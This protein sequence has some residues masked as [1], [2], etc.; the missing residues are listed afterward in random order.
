MSQTD[1]NLQR[2]IQGTQLSD[3]GDSS[4]WQYL[5]WGSLAVLALFLLIIPHFVGP[6]YKFVLSLWAVT[7]IAAQGLNLMMGYAG[8]VSL[9]QGAFMG[10]GAYVSS[11]LVQNG[12]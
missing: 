7:A 8:K 12:E 6:Y 11:L 4:G 2:K 10:I 3:L 5:K 9:A 1:N